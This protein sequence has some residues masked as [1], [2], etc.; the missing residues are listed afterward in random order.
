MGEGAGIGGAHY[1]GYALKGC[2]LYHVV[3]G[4]WS[5]LPLSN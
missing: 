3:L 5:S 2:E 1:L 4:L